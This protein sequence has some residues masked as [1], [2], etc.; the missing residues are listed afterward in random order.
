MPRIFLISKCEIQNQLLLLCVRAKRNAANINC[1]MIFDYQV[2]LGK[3]EY[4]RR[5]IS[6]EINYTQPI[7][8]IFSYQF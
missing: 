8:D 2:H 6:D 4:P 7:K 1:L 3:I 5:Y